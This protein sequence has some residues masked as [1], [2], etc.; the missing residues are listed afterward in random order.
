MFLAVVS[1]AYFLRDRKKDIDQKWT[2][3][4]LHEQWEEVLWGFIKETSQEKWLRS[5]K[6]EVHEVDVLR[7]S[8]SPGKIRTKIAIRSHDEP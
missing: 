1:G 4:A 3:N 8:A 5:L 2:A 7:G 6:A